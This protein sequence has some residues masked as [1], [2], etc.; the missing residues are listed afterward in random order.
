MNENVVVKLKNGEERRFEV[1]GGVWTSGV[2]YEGAFVIIE[3][4]YGA[5]TSFPAA[6]VAEIFERAPSRR[7]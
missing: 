4:T 6:D 1:G 7:L 2:R 3:D 5:K